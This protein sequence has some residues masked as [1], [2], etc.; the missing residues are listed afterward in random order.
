M[1]NLEKNGQGAREW[2]YLRMETKVVCSSIG[3]EKII[4]YPEDSVLLSRTGGQGRTTPPPTLHALCVQS[5]LQ[6]LKGPFSHFLT[7]A[8]GKDE[9]AN[10]PTEYAT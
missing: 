8:L 3:D 9:R 10:R 6:H 5:Q 4:E 7:G 1:K 2:E